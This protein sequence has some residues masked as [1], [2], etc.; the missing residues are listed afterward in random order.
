MNFGKMLK[1]TIKELLHDE[2]FLSD[3][4]QYVISVIQRPAVRSKLIQMGLKELSSPDVKN[5]IRYAIKDIGVEEALSGLKYERDSDHMEI[6][7]LLQDVLERQEC[8]ETEMEH[9]G[10]SSLLNTV[11]ERQERIESEIEKLKTWIMEGDE[12]GGD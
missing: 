6:I 5:T 4:L 12:S 9:E 8:I 1:P 7:Y 3:I 2:A 10:I 11:L